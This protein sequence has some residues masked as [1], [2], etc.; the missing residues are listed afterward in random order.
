MAAGERTVNKRKELY[1]LLGDNIT[2]LKFFKLKETGT[3][4]KCN[5]KKK[6]KKLLKQSGEIFPIVQHVPNTS[7]D[8]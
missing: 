1:Y 6:K 2:G 8:S 4:R 5:Q 7:Q 3:E